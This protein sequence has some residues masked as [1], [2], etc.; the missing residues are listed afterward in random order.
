MKRIKGNTSNDRIS[1]SPIT[2]ELTLPLDHPD[3]ETPNVLYETHKFR[4]DHL[5]EVLNTMASQT[6]VL[7]LID[8]NR[9]FDEFID[10]IVRKLK[11]GGYVQ[12]HVFKQD[13]TGA[14]AWV[15]SLNQMKKECQ[16]KRAKQ[17]TVMLEPGGPQPG[18][19]DSAPLYH[20]PP[21]MF[22]PSDITEKESQ[23]LTCRLAFSS[24]V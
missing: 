18:G 24:R 4:T 12:H 21:Q 2:H 11:K 6:H 5:D 23:I 13:K 20:W 22:S 16:E 17:N 19:S 10:Q 3:G 9:I 15:K 7:I 14:E 1:L 8:T